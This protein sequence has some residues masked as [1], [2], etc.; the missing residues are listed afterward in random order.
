MR[1]RY[2]TQATSGLSL[3]SPGTILTFCKKKVVTKF[4]NFF[5]C[6][7]IFEF[8]F[9]PLFI[10]AIMPVLQVRYRRRNLPSLH[11]VTH[12]LSL[13]SQ[14][15]LGYKHTQ[16]SFLACTRLH[17][18][19]AQFL[20][21]HQVTHTLS[22]VSQLALGYTHTQPSF[23][24]CT[25]LYTHSAQFLSLHQVT[26]TLSLVSQLAL[27]YTHTQPSVLACTRLHTHSAQFLV[28]FSQLFYDRTFLNKQPHN[29]K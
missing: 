7:K 25:R 1:A 3:I 12:T 26:H 27:G 18:H 15:A 2:T 28:N 11:Q 24:A 14:L 22:L 17:T 9:Q 8:Y 19:L 4:Q 23:L 10:F 6:L 13:V 21:L 20:S 5:N 29:I 16:P